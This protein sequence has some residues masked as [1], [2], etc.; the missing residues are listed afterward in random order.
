MHPVEREE[1]AGRNSGQSVNGWVFNIQRY[2]IHDGPGIRTTVFLKGCPLRCFWCHNPESQ[3]SRP[4]IFLDPS[5]CTVCGECVTVCPSGAASLSESSPSI[6]RDICIRCGQCTEVC[7]S[8]ARKLIGRE[9]N[10]DEVVDEVLKDR[11]FYEN[12]GGGVTLSGGDPLAQ[13][14][15]SRSILQ[16]CR[17]A[18][19]HT[20]IET[21]GYG[22]WRSM[23]PL[24]EYT[25]LVLFDIKHM[26]S[27]RHHDG[28]GVHNELILENARKVARLKP[29]VVRVPVIPGFNDSP[30]DIR[31]IAQ[32]VKHSLGLQ[33]M[34]L[35]PFNSMAADKYRM[36]DLPYEPGKRKS[37]AH[38]NSLIAIV[39]EVMN[40]PGS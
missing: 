29:V 21:C 12:S 13:R 33:K 14:D 2:S 3:T 39:A 17:A 16:K 36:L 34:E 11:N 28:T 7:I 5:K 20:V 32:F 4:D 23:G 24:L 15:F 35:L 19:L 26:D 37:D 31:D 30:S 9:M 22:G 38:M 18:G 40:G 1:E 27:Q 8:G 10:C 25:D 6:D